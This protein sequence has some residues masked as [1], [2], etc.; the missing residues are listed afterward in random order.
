MHDASDGSDYDEGTLATENSKKQN[1]TVKKGEEMNGA[2][3]NKGSQPSI[4]GE[5]RRR[6]IKKKQK[7]KTN[8]NRKAN[9]G[10]NQNQ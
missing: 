6:K 5:R 10:G 4:L 9:R 8:T 3:N 2:K 7:T 1:Y